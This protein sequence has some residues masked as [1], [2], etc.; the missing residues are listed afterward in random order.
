MESP[1]WT[2]TLIVVLGVAAQWLAWRVRVPSILLLL[3]SGL[4]VGPVAAWLTGEALLDPDSIIGEDLLLSLV[5]ISV[6]LILYEGG[7]SL[8]FRE[9][10]GTGGAVW[11]LVSI[12]AVATWV[13][14]GLSAWWLLDMPPAIATLLGGIMVVT[15]P[16]VVGPLISHI[17]PRGPSAAVLRWEGIVIDPVGALAA[18]LVYEAILAVNAAD[19]TA[20]AGAMAVAMAIATTVVVGGGLGLLAAWLLAIAMQR[21]WIPEHL[22]NPVSLLLVVAIFV[23]A[24]TVQKESGLLATTVMGIALANQRRANVG[25]ILEFKENL[26]ILLISA[27]F[28]VLGARLAPDDLRL[29]DWPAAVFVATLIFIVR[30][31]S[32]WL[33]TIGV[34]FDLRQRLFIAWLAP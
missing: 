24:D 34:G 9:I 26:R 5:G 27:L 31:V 29:I 30:P 16:T 21:Y 14:A 17:R 19:G 18:V 28:V 12:G 20:A 2:I 32:V 3:A 8:R 10:A 6:G 15:G 1:A 11:R 22:Q 4:V 13:L 33:S 25:H 23:A 7:L